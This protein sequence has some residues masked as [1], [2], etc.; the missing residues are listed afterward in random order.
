MKTARRV[1]L[2]A[3]AGDRLLFERFVSEESR[4]PLGSPLALSVLSK[5][6]P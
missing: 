6:G 2:L 1:I 4:E 5:S 3:A